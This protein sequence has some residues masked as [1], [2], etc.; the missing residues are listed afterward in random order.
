[1]IALLAGITYGE[2][3]FKKAMQNMSQR[4]TNIH[5]GRYD[6]RTDQHKQRSV[7]ELLELARKG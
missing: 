7:A 5:L 6:L 3:R 4:D 1:M 2:Y